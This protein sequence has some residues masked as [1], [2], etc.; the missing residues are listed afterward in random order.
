[1][2]TYFRYG[3]W[4]R[5]QVDQAA[6]ASQPEVPPGLEMR[7]LHGVAN[8]L[9]VTGR[10]R[11][12]RSEDGSH[13]GP[14]Q[15]THWNNSRDV[16]MYRTCELV[17]WGTQWSELTHCQSTFMIGEEVVLNYKAIVGYKNF[18]TNA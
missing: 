3:A 11:R 2:V 1:M 6:L 14:Q 18:Q 12:L 17:Q 4:V 8:A 10:L 7:D 15:V 16:V 13:A 5:V 9:H